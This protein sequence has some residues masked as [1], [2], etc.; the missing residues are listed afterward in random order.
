MAASDIGWVEDLLARTLVIDFEMV[1]DGGIFHIG[2]SLG[3]DQLELERISDEKMALSALNRFSREA[4]YVMGHNIWSH[5]LP[6]ARRVLPEAPFLSL[7]VIDTLYMSPLA[8]PSNPY[9]R[10]VKNY[11]LVREGKNNPL[12]DVR[13]TRQVVKEQIEALT[14]QAR[15]DLIRFFAFCFAGSGLSGIADLFSRICGALPEPGEAAELFLSLCGDK[16]C[17]NGLEQTWRD[18]SPLPEKRLVLAFLTSWIRVSGG[19][20]VMPPWVSHAFP[21]IREL[22]HRLRYACTDSNC[23]YC[24]ENN[25]AETLLERYFGFEGFRPLPDG[26]H[27]QKEIVACGLKGHS[28][29]GILPTG[30]G[31]SIC[32]QIPALHR[33]H[34]TGELTLIISPLK[35]L[36]KDQVDN[37]NQA[38]GSEVAAAING[39]LTLPERGAVMERVRLGDVGLLYISPEQLRNYSIAEL[40]QT[41]DVGGW[42]FDEAH[43]L[44]KWGHDFRP[45]YLHVADFI[46]QSRSTGQALPFVGAYTATAKQDVVAEIMGHLGEKLDL[47]LTFFSGGVNRDNLAFH[48]FPV[49]RNEKFDVIYSLLDKGLDPARGGAIVYCASRKQTERISEFLTEKGMTAQAF[50]AGKSEPDKI[51]IQ[52]DFVKGAVPIICATNAFGMGIDKK[53]IRL[54]I[55]ADIPGSLENYLQEAGR[56]GRDTKDA[57]CVLLYE[58]E[59]V[60]KQFSLN[61]LSRLSLDDIKK[62]LRVLKKKGVN[63]PKIVITPSEI[64][65]LAGYPEADR[66]DGRAK[67]AV[68]WLE[69][70]GFVNRS[71]NE[72]LFFKGVPRVKDM[73][74]ARARIA[75]LGLSL[76]MQA[77]YERVL[78]YLFNADKND[79][80][81]ADEIL[82]SLGGIAGLD[83]SFADSRRI[84]ALLSEM[85]RTGLIQEGVIMT[86][87]VR[88][89]GKN[90]SLSTLTTCMQMEAAMLKKMEESYPEAGIDPDAPQLINLRLMSQHLQDQGFA[91]I[92]ADGVETLLRA[93]AKD[94]GKLKGRGVKIS[95]R[96]GREQQRIF[97]T[98]PWSRIRERMGL[99]HAGAR[100]CLETIVSR[101]PK[102]HQRGQAQVLS[103]FFVSDLARAIQ[104]E[105]VS[106]YRFAGDLDR[107]IEGVLLYLHDIQAI[108]LQ[109]G[110]GVFRQAMT[111]TMPQ[112][113]G[114]AIYT[115]ADYEPLA[116]HYEQKNIQVHVMEKYAQLGLE[117][118]QAALRFVSDYFSSSHDTFIRSHFAGQSRIIKTA[119][120]ARAYQ[121]VV[122][123]LENPVQEEIVT[124]PSARNI[125]VLAG[126]GSGKTRAIVHRC[127]WLIKARSVLPSAILVLCFNH[128]AMIELRKR[129]RSLT[130]TGG[131]GVTAMTYH[132]FAMRLTGRS[133]LS[134]EKE[135][136][137]QESQG[138]DSIIDEAADLLETKG[139]AMGMETGEARERLLS[140]YRYILV[141]EYQDIDARQ[142]RFISALTGMIET[143]PDARISIMAVGDDDQ[144]IYGFRQ[145]NVAFIRQFKKDYDAGTYYMVENYR[146]SQAVIQAANAL[147]G[148]NRD[149]MKTQSPCRINKKRAGQVLTARDLP[150]RDKVFLVRAEDHLSQAVFMAR[151][152]KELLDE[153]PDLRPSD[154]AVLSRQGISFPCLVAVRMAL[155][156]LEIPFSYTLKK[157]AGFP[158]LR[159]REILEFF[160]GLE[161]LAGKALKPERLKADCMATFSS[162]N[163]WTALVED[164]LDAWCHTNG[165]RKIT[166]ARAQEFVLE[167]L[168]EERREHRIGKGVFLGT[169]HSAKGMEFVHVFMPDGG[170]QTGNEEEERRLYYVGMTRAKK[171]L[172][173]GMVPDWGNPHVHAL[174]DCPYLY[175]TRAPGAQLKGWDPGL[176]V[177]ILGLKELF[178]S[179]PGYFEPDH[180][181]HAT[182]AGLA[183]GDEIQLKPLP[184]KSGLYATDSRNRIVGKLSTAAAG[185]WQERLAGIV[186]AR[187][188][189]IVRRRKGDG[190]EPNTEGLK[191]D[192]WEL[193]VIEVLHKLPG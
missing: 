46:V 65:G 114:R 136:A 48:V 135:S 35:A 60:E 33:Y 167:T 157:T 21:E 14:H 162:A 23:P 137:A 120:T 128:Q 79:L 90:S 63:T 11:K 81:S 122:E 78:S 47:E 8:F 169:V 41:R 132:G 42:I 155:A 176:T 117:K 160:A 68:S 94:K 107:F 58:Q 75:Q 113:E 20:S 109:N 15:P 165:D 72:T 141:D 129:I 52:D 92:N 9:H 133:F 153:D 34:R 84:M 12:A 100:I 53:D 152:I 66:D 83:P 149:R 148:L 118:V 182:L 172:V 102:Q 28:L 73:E 56:A 188:L 154:I 123:S 159:V 13:L 57:E 93:L 175:G 88:P 62:I 180:P 121:E 104:F 99:R 45:D 181:V 151:K 17:R 91:A 119:M 26:T 49:S 25:H 166:T 130:G 116:H 29:L 146:S 54:V 40:I 44:S 112:Q 19:N 77:V 31:K 86:A 69:R 145:A 139:L 89:K 171:G 37:L 30:G 67:T 10:L 170:W 108:V 185:I 190:E 143:D 127:A 183:A 50:H 187:V 36:M 168:L 59:D 43:C 103:E 82:A 1:P 131:L 18:Y 51:N 186:R 142:Y 163:M 164:I 32:Y 193:P 158:V 3:G 126:P 101:L 111:L 150:D 39:S 38:L 134:R 189:A 147:I 24:R 85:A 55:H 156:G 144:S 173:L 110:L 184:G 76:K 16:A 5:D 4:D 124:A 177:S 192:S 105:D 7:P 161:A 174:R 71:F 2:A 6:A 61:N 74:E 191:V 179:Y 80:I 98:V 178:I 70:R 96:R 115:K 138:F 87:F 22:V 27:L 140:K 95:G 64:M 125:L 106:L 97:V